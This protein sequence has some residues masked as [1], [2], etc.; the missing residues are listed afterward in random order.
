MLAVLGAFVVACAWS[1]S[2]RDESE[3]AEARP[4][5][6]VAAHGTAPAGALAAEEMAPTRFASAGVC[7]RCHV[8]SVLEW[9]VSGHVEAETTCQECHGTSR[10]HVANERNEVKPDRRPTGAQIAGLC[11]DC[12]DDGCPQTTRKDTCQECHHQHALLNPSKPVSGADSPRQQLAVRWSK[13]QEAME[14]GER[15]ASTVQW[16]AAG[17]AFERALTLVPSSREAQERWAA[18]ARRLEPTLPGF[19][20]VGE[21]VDFRLGLPREVQ[22]VGTDLRMMLVPGGEADIGDEGFVSSSPV[23]TVQLK[24]FYLGKF[25][26]TQ[27]QWERWMGENPSHHRGER[28]PQASRMPVEQVSWDDC[29]RFVER[30]NQTVPGGGFRLPTEAEWEFAARAA[31]EPDTP[32]VSRAVFRPLDDGE[33]VPELFRGLDAFTPRPVGS[34]S[35]EAGGLYDLFGNV[36]EWCA[37]PFEPYGVVPAVT[38]GNPRVLRGGS[39]ADGTAVLHPAFRH[40]ER[41]GRRLRYNGLRIARTLL[42]PAKATETNSGSENAGVEER[43]ARE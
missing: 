35:P 21:A 13:Y 30:L 10:A 1:G 32:L 23:H 43:R 2:E 28:F 16:S 33:V 17:R 36:N 12:H 34:L 5:N 40:R 11:M 19:E 24:S 25:E 29:Q 8:L 31:G 22:V 18:C 38:D 4:D 9:G 37:D 3:T 7:S 6:R 14:E 27:A 20:S 41:P 15:L 42:S 39:F 26:I